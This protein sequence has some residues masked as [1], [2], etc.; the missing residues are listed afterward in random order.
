MK[1]A[2]VCGAGGFIGHHLVKRLKK[3]GYWVR[4]VDQKQPEFGGTEADQF[5]ILD[6]RTREGCRSALTTNSVER[7]EFDEVYQLAADMGGMGFIHTA[8]CDIMRNSALI[9]INMINEAIGRLQVPRYFFSSSVC[10]YRDMVVGEPPLTEDGAYPAMPDNEYGWEKLYA[11][12]MAMTFGRHHGTAVRIARFQ[13]CYGPEGTWEGGRE[14]APAAICRKIAMSH[15]GDV[16]DCWGDG[17]ASRCYT[18]IDDMVDGIYKLTQSDIEGPANIGS[19]E[20]VTVNQLIKTV[21]GIADKRINVKH[22]EG[23]VGV[24]YRAFTKEKIKQ[25]GWE[26]SHAFLEGIAYTYEWVEQ[27]VKRSNEA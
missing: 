11:E 3:E 21:A 5:L 2:L 24:Q 25:T 7:S 23:P 12:R 1:R 6:L 9:N 26:A 18:Y 20:H 19:S 27:Q 4:G 8:E 22:V 10:V 17:S 15:S 13:N 16:I 14:K